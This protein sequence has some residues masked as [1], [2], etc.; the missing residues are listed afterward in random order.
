MEVLI[1]VVLVVLTVVMTVTG[2]VF[3]WVSLD[4]NCASLS[5]TPFRSNFR[6][7]FRNSVDEL[8]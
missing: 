7:H 3:S 6:E 4:L 1:V 2:T 8:E 5:E